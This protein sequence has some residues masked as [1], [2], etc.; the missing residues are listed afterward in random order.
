M[1]KIWIHIFST[2]AKAIITLGLVLLAV[3]APGFAEQQRTYVLARAPQLTASVLAKRWTPLVDF[4]SERTGK[5]IV[6]KLYKNRKEFEADLVAGTPDFF[7]TNPAHYVFAKRHHG[8]AA[9]ARSNAWRLSGI[10]VVQRDSPVRSV[11]ELDG[12]DLVF[13]SRTSLGASLYLRSILE[14]N[15]KIDFTPHYVDTH[16]NVYRNVANG[17]FVAGGGVARTLEWE[18]PGLRN[19]L[20]VLYET[21]GLAPHPLS[22]HPRVPMELRDA[23]RRAILELDQTESGRAM[24][25]SVGLG[26]PIATDDERDYSSIKDLAEE[27]HADLLE[28]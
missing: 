24:L 27:I 23:V 12:K 4:L 19:A 22:A 15:E 13:P 14:R 17:V 16:D 9:L 3:A 18:P 10:L 28:H 11:A 7:Y 8:Y 20:R 1:N 21:P 6:L 2:R 25:D 5:R 26:R